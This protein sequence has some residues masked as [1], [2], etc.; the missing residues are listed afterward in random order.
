MNFINKM[1]AFNSAALL[2]CFCGT[3]DVAMALEGDSS[4]P[5]YI[6]SNSATYDDTKGISI[7]LGDV[8]VNQGSMR[9]NSD[10]LI[11]YLKDGRIDKLVAKGAPARFK[12]TPE[13]GK[14]DIKGKSLRAEYYPDKAQLLLI[15]KAVVWQGENTYASEIIEYDNKNA[16][17]KA[18]EESTDSKRVH[19]VL[20][21][22]K[23]K[24][25]DDKSADNN[26]N[27]KGKTVEDDKTGGETSSKEI[28]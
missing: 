12:Q 21:P 27:E 9:M 18:G 23:D 4:K 7:Y 13:P 26:T 2:M 16:I 3:S 10:E 20:Q 6:E 17:V 14:E 11:I 5:I 19:V 8:E 25:T 1:K 24:S 22:N 15:K 28:Q